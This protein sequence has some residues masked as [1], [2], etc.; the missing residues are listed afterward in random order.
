MYNFII[1]YLLTID[2]SR[3]TLL[4]RSQTL[5]K[6]R[7]PTLKLR[8]RRK[9]YSVRRLFTGFAIAAF[10]AWKLIV[11]IVIRIAIIA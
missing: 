8:R 9:H 3:L 4:F 11:I 10:I 7:A 5:F 6:G 2:D 1:S